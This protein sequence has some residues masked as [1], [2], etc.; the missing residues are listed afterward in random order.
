MFRY[1][2]AFFFLEDG[3]GA[4]GW[5]WGVTRTKNIQDIV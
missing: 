4:M 3:E 1:S 5:R 2:L